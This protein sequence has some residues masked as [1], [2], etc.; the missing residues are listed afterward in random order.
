[1]KNKFGQLKSS[2]DVEVLK[3]E[4]IKGRY[5][6][7]KKTL[8]N[9]TSKLKEDEE[10]VEIY[11]NVLLLFEKASVVARRK[12]KDE[13]ELLITHGLQSVFE[14]PGIAFKV[15]FVS[16]RNQIEADFY[17]EWIEQEKKIRGNIVDSFGGGIVDIISLVLRLVV[18]ELSG[19]LGPLFLDE[20]GKMLSEQYIPNFGNF[21][22][23]LSKTFG[24]QIILITH[25]ELLS[26]YASKTFV[27]SLD[28]KGESVVNG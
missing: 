10:R 12:I 26:A 18:L 2:F 22:V 15:E 5:E 9:I 13:I 6:E 16:R 27:V 8:E 7:K 11:K 3:L 28:E 19:T 20:P 4:R 25:D 17:L 24:R 21:L 1:M 14:D 23:E